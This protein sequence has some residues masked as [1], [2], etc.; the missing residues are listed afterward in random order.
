MKRTNKN[1][2]SDSLS[3]LE[4][5]KKLSKENDSPFLISALFFYSCE[6]YMYSGMQ[7]AEGGD[8][9]SFLERWRGKGDAFRKLG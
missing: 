5:S 9:T 1:K 8:L 2:Q 6:K 4:L 3:S 7:I